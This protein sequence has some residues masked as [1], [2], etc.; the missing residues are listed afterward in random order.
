MT[1]EDELVCAV[2][3][4]VDAKTAW[5]ES[6]QEI[7]SE[8]FLRVIQA[9]ID[10]FSVGD[11][12]FE[13]RPLFP[14]VE[15]LNIEFKAFELYMSGAD[16]VPRHPF[17]SAISEL[18]N[19]MQFAPPSVNDQPI[20]SIQE[21]VSTGVGHRQIAVIYSHECKGPF[22]KD[23]QPLPYLVKQEISNPGSVLGKDFVHPRILA[24]RERAV[25]YENHIAKRATALRD[26]REAMEPETALPVGVESIEELIVQGVTDKQIM[27]IKGCDLTAV[28][29][30]RNRMDAA[31]RGEGSLET[32]QEVEGQIRAYIEANP[33]DKNADIAETV[34]ATT[35]QV[36]SVRQRMKKA[37]A[38]V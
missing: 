22:M 21:L 8:E 9:T 6:E 1:R 31:K 36:A 25:K 14:V 26:N 35:K 17:W 3:D 32:T 13:C 29:T 18:E 34:G 20:E 2:M 16:K 7:L 15:R 19:A 12:P 4:L 27:T 38:T 23:K 24:E 10:T 37:P 5:Q 30:V 28:R 33:D 11:M